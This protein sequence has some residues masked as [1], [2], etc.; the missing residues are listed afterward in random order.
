MGELATLANVSK[1]TIDYYTSLGLLQANRS[2]SNYRIYASEA[3]EDLK[4]I[5][6]YKELGASLSTIRK[7]MEMKKCQEMN[8]TIVQQH[9]EAVSKHMKQLEMELSDLAPVIEGL[10]SQQKETI[11]KRL[12]IE[13]ALLVQSLHFL[14]K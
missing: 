13:S 12:T 4:F 11:Y 7:K 10:N 2:K 6:R 3:L 8:E 9:I 1:R 14:T 5:E